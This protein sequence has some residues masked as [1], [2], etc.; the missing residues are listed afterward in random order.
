[1]DLRHDEPGSSIAFL[2]RR[3]T[4]KGL[5]RLRE[6]I[7]SM[8]ILDTHEHL[9]E[10]SAYRTRF[11]NFLAEY[12]SHYFREDLVLA[13]AQKEALALLSDSS[14]GIMDLWDA[15][16]PAWETARFTG[17]GQALDKTARILYGCTGID[18]ESI[19]WID[20]QYNKRKG[21]E[22]RIQ[23]TM[24]RCGIENMIN[25]DPYPYCTFACWVNELIR[26]CFSTVD[27]LEKSTGV[28]IATLDDWLEA[29]RRLLDRSFAGGAVA[30]K[31]SLAY[32]RSLE[33]GPPDQRAAAESFRRIFAECQSEGQEREEALRECE[34]FQDYMMHFV[35]TDAAR[36]R[37]PFQI[38]T[39][40][41]AQGR[42][43]IS[44]ADPEKLTSLL[45]RHPDVDFDVFHIGY[46]YSRV[47][48]AL[49][50][51][52]GNVRIDMCWSHS[53]SPRASMEFLGEW[54]EMLPVNRILAFGGDS[55]FPDVLC[56]ASLQA[57][58]IVFGALSPKVESGLMDVDRAIGIARRL[59]Y[60]N[61]KE[62]FG[63]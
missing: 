20:S 40:L 56:G 34:V 22:D 47:L 50:K 9:D 5:D 25:H 49:A 28:H 44:N 51:M 62:H 30:Y 14:A 27:D 2:K 8:P 29:S 63:L 53:I 19:N 23:D 54:L 6:E 10:E 17:Y 35:L 24:A 45:L 1:L 4:M 46:P 21:R 18:R 3:K 43:R 7:L 26:P 11:P 13:G 41:L 59:L 12:A 58:E 55:S 61:A 32:Y 60:Q 36:R 33:Y 37:R 38:H 39:G 15:I 48:G 42:N 16:E 57:R 52:F 31:H